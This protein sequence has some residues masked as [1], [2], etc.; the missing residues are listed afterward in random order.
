MRWVEAFPAWAVTLLG[1][2][3]LLGAA[4][5]IVGLAARSQWSPLA[6]WG[7]AA[8]ALG[9]VVM[10]IGAV[11]T[12]VRRRESALPPVVPGILAL[13]AEITV[14]SRVPDQEFE[15][16]GSQIY[17]GTSSIEGTLLGVPVSG[18]AWIEQAF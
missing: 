7:I 11:I 13:V 14:T 18:D 4:G 15:V 6:L 5:I 3:E 17:E 10:M 1:V 9:L 2:L 8:A 12:D 16:P